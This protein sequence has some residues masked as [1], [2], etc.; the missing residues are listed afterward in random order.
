[1]SFS[2]DVKNELENVISSARHCQ[3]AELYAIESLNSKKLDESTP[4]GRKAF[5]L[6]KKTSIIDRCVEA[7]IKNSC[8][9][10]AYLRGA[11]LSVGHISDPN[12]SYDLEFV[13]TEDYQVQTIMGYMGSFGIEMKLTSRKG[14]SVVYIKDADSLVDALNVMGAHNALMY[15]ENLRVEKD[16]RNLINRQV[17]C[18]AANI[19]KTVKAAEKQINDI[20]K[21]EKYLGLDKLP[22]QL[23]EIAKLRLEHTESSLTELGEL[24]NPPVGK[25]GVNHRLR[26]LSEIA[27][28]IKD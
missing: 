15:I 11:F 2:Q 17:N 28:T 6:R 10:R 5:T 22:I 12:K 23:K 13:C 27:D 14:N 18:E 9:R 4:A 7:N 25:S 1:M 26:K 19:S 16:F 24:L 3:L 21:I 20:R 8:C